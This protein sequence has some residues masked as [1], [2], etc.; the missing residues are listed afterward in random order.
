M[1]RPAT[2][3]LV[4]VSSLLAHPTRATH[5]K[6][7]PTP[8]GGPSASGDPELL[9]TFD[10]GPNPTTTPKVLD[11]LARHRLHAVFFL[12]GE[13]VDTRNKRVPAILERILREGHVI[14]NHTMTHKDLCRVSAKVGAAEID[15]G[16]EAIQRLTQVDPVWF[17]APFG[18]RCARIEA[19]L[20]ERDL[21]H[22]HWDLDPQEWKHNDKQKTV[23]YVTGEL[24]RARHRS[25]LLLHDIKPVTVDALPEILAW[26]TA[27]NARRTARNE[28]PIRILEPTQLALEQ[29][30]PGLASWASDTLARLDVRADLARVVP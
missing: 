14:A 26:I 22:L 20:A 25:V 5:A 4:L 12:V 27:E 3:V 2:L 1:V 29:L 28:R 19:L 24:A 23:D 16:R 21:H 9:L 7:W 17:R 13:M 8:A 18:V 11:I 6:G 10:D 15:R 30:S